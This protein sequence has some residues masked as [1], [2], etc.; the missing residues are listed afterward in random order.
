MLKNWTEAQG[1]PPIYDAQSVCLILGTMPSPVSRAAKR[2]Y[3][4]PQ[5]RFWKVLAALWE[6]SV[7]VGKQEQTDFLLRHHIAL[8]DVLASCEIAGA[9]DDSIRCPAV[10]DLTVILNQAPIRRIFTTGQK[11]YFLFQEF[12]RPLV[13]QDAVCLPSTSPANRRYTTKALTEAYRAVRLA[14]EEA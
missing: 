10:N 14:L 5:N 13:R 11:A 1:L 8:W 7:P 2:Y 9:R 12:C 6:E 4:H 3:A